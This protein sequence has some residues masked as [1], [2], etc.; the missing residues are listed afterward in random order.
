VPC[1]AIERSIA[2]GSCIGEL[3]WNSMEVAS[4]MAEP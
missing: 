3:I 2:S 4:V 1:S